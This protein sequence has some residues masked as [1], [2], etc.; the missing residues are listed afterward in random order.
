MLPFDD[1]VL[2]SQ[3]TEQEKILR[4]VQTCRGKVLLHN[5]FQFFQGR[6]RRTHLLLT[7]QTLELSGQLIQF[8]PSVFPGQSEKFAETTHI[9]GQ[10]ILGK[11]AYRPQMHLKSVDEFP[12]QFIECNVLFPVEILD[13]RLQR[14]ITV[15]IT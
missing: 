14:F 15:I 11:L 2:A 7:E 3:T 12:T 1:M 13:D 6:E 4:C 5:P 9:L 8:Q 10:G